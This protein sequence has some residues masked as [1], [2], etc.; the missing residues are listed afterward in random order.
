M[1]KDAFSELDDEPIFS[2]KDYRFEDW[3]A[4]SIFCVLAV[5]VFSQF[6]SRYVLGSSLG[7]TEEVAR[8]LLVIVGFLGASMGVRK[9]AHIFVSLFVRLLPEKIA[10]VIDIITLI[11]STL[12]LVALAVFAVQIIP[13]IHIYE[14]ASIPLP[15]SALYGVVLF[16]LIM[17]LIR[18]VGRLLAL[19]TSK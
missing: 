6:F 4:L 9:N 7:W 15:M 8:Y 1:D 12:F 5:T 17:M 10:R 2:R 13:R 14:M 11:F 19:R 16:S 3:I 18:S